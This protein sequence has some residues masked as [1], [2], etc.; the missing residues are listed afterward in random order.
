MRS[1]GPLLEKGHLGFGVIAGITRGGDLSSA[2]G[3]YIAVVHPPRLTS[4]RLPGSKKCA[5]EPDSIVA[6]SL[7]LKENLG[8][9]LFA[10]ARAQGPFE[11]N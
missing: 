8:L 10:R 11:P 9:R 2:S 6:V 7:R 4:Q 5:C 1:G 3:A